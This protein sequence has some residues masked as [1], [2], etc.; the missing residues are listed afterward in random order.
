MSTFAVAF[1]ATPT[2]L[3]TASHTVCPAGK[4]RFNHSHPRSTL[5]RIGFGNV[6]RPSIKGQHHHPIL[7]RGLMGM[8]A[9]VMAK[10]EMGVQRGAA[11]EALNHRICFKQVRIGLV[12]VPGPRTD[13]AFPSLKE[14]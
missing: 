5:S 3:V 10:G 1:T 14:S 6:E 11:G 8:G 4:K 7:L 2:A 13:P 12:Q 9:E